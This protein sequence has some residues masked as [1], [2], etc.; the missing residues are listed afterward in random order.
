M[1]DVLEREAIVG[2]R[3]FLVNGDGVLKSCFMTYSYRAKNV[4]T[5]KTSGP[6]SCNDRGFWTFNRRQIRRE[7]MTLADGEQITATVKCW[8]RVAIH[9]GGWRSSHLRI[10]S[11]SCNARYVSEEVS[12]K[13]AKRYGVP[14]RRYYPYREN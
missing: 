9:S 13:I 7:Q 1:E 11:V 2:F 4:K 14:V 5:A 8:G 12:K 10:V 3:S 6:T